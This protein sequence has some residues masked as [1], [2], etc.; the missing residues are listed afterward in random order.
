MVKK[1]EDTIILQPDKNQ[2]EGGPKWENIPQTTHQNVALGSLSPR[3]DNRNLPP[4]PVDP[5]NF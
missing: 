3:R 1:G 2:D 5:C 4:P